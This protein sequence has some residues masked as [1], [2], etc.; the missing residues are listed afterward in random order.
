MSA[1]ASPNLDVVLDM[2]SHADANLSYFAASRLPVIFKMLEVTQEQQAME[3]LI[4][5]LVEMRN[6]GRLEDETHEFIDY[7]VSKYRK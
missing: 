7:C 5:K 1:N 3:K 4:E 6:N 2:L